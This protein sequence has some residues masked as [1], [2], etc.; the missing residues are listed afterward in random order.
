MIFRNIKLFILFH[1]VFLITHPVPLPELHFNH[2]IYDPQ[3]CINNDV[4][5]YHFS[6]IAH[7]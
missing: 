2:D 3:I 4:I 5:H 1:L 6:K 7:K